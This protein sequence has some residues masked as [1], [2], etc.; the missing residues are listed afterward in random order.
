MLHATHNK[1]QVEFEFIQVVYKQLNKTAKQHLNFGHEISYQKSTESESQQPHKWSS[2]S[3][4]IEFFS[5]DRLVTRCR[6]ITTL[7]KIFCHVIWNLFDSFSFSPLTYGSVQVW[8]TLPSGIRDD[9]AF[10]S[11]RTEY[12]RLPGEWRIMTQLN[13]SKLSSQMMKII[14]TPDSI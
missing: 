9:P 3:E 2:V 5:G 11:F 7:N 14:Q 13:L 8:T 4:K 6:Y 1:Y 12:E 10:S